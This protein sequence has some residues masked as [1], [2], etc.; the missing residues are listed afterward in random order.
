MDYKNEFAFPS[1]NLAA[2]EGLTK[3]EYFTAA[4]LTGLLACR[5]SPIGIDLYELAEKAATIAR[6]QLDEIEKYQ[7]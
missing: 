4:A 6:F 5:T 3:L 7:K 2:V 1:S